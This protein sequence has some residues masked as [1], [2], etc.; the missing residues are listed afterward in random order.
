MFGIIMW[1]YAM[2]NDQLDNLAG[3][4]GEMDYPIYLTSVYVYNITFIVY[5]G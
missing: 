1:F 4:N 2:I 3:W 5:E